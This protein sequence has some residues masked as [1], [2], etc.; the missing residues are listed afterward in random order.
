MASS[1]KRSRGS[2]RA[3]RL[4]PWHRPAEEDRD[5]KAI[6]A[7]NFCSELV[8][9]SRDNTIRASEV[10]CRRASGVR[11]LELLNAEEFA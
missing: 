1:N 8:L 10:N 9:H 5:P 3:V 7:W 6:T 2:Q 4:A 11:V